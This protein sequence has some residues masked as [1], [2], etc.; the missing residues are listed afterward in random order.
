MARRKTWREKLAFHKGL[1]KVVVISGK[2]STRWG[3]GTCAIPAPA[4]I[5]ALMRQVP[6]GRLVTT[7]ELRA[8]IARKH[9]ATIGCPIT[10]GIFATIAAHAAEEAAAA[11]EKK[12]TPYWRTL[13]AGGELNPKYPGGIAALK[14][15][16]EAEGHRVVPAGRSGK[17]F[18]VAEYESRLF[19]QDGGKGQEVADDASDTGVRHVAC[20]GAGGRRRGVR[21][22]ARRRE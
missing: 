10:T 17:R 14:R 15:R 2:M 8:A 12:I 19:A 6:R 11:G 9:G 21:L 13:K 4:E 1:P 18:V 5:D 3:T 7:T 16:L 22:A 20:A